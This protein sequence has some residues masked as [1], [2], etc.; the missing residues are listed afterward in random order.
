MVNI[1]QV[2]KTNGMEAAMLLNKNGGSVCF[3]PIEVY[4]DSLNGLVKKF[5]DGE[6]VQPKFCADC[7]EVIVQKLEEAGFFDD[8]AEVRAKCP[9]V[10]ISPYEG[11]EEVEVIKAVVTDD[12]RIK[13][14]A[15]VTEESEAYVG[16]YDDT[17]CLYLS[18]NFVYEEIGEK[19]GKGGEE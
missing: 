14:L 19:L 9:Y 12:N 11:G 5:F 4:E 13:F 10:L 3:V 7:S 17:D 6:N 18:Q 16:W 15:V 8:C 1:A 2:V